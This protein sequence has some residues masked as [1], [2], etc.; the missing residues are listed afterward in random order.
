MK[1]DDC[2]YKLARRMSPKKGITNLAR[3]HK[4]SRTQKSK[5]RS[6]KR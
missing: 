3:Q 1:N 5:V 2:K 4:T 6:L